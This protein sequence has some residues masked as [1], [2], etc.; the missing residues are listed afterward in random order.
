MELT[1]VKI[2]DLIKVVDERNTQKIDNFYGINI[3]KEF[4]PTKANTDNLDSS[5]YKIVE[6]NRFVFSGM[7][8]GRDECIRIS[9]YQGQKPVIVSPAY[10]TFEVKKEASI[11]SEYLNLFFHSRERDRLGWF[12]S[13]SSIRS[14]LDWDSFCNITIYLPSIE[15]QQKYVDIYNAMIA[16]QKAY[17]SGL[18]DLRLLLDSLLNNYKKTA[19]REKLSCLLT[20][21]DQ[22]NFDGRVN[23][24]KGI[25]ILKQFM[26]SVASTTGVDFKKYKIVKKNQLAFSGMQTGRDECIRIALSKNQEPIIISP[27][28]TVFNVNTEEVAPEY[29]MM[30]FSRK[31][32]DRYG[33]FLSDSSIRSNL[34]LDRF[35][36]IE[37]PV[38]STKEQSSLVSIYSAYSLR[39][40]LNEQL[41]EQI[42]N[43]CPILIKGSIEEARKA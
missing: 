21:V 6:K 16:N 25:N 43:I 12:L 24:L 10:T 11:L 5:K 8:T 1:E 42:K 2:G 14:N 20:E 36:D 22:R 28:Y 17:E 27:A 40:Q 30:W 31:E 18:E 29:I 3:D 39:R 38:P 19:K 26:N 23:D 7:Q 34:D 15:I 32:I 37:I 4:I 33:W 13:D 35:L 41:K 9:L